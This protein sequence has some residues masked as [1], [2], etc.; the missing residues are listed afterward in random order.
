MDPEVQAFLTDADGRQVA[1][2]MGEELCLVCRR[3]RV[4]GPD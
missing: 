2:R 1:T 4:M 3:E